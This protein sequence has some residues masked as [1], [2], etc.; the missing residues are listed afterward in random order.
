M[1]LVCQH[2]NVLFWGRYAGKIHSF[3]F[4]SSS[5][6]YLFQHVRRTFRNIL[7]WFWILLLTWNLIYMWSENDSALLTCQPI[8]WSHAHRFTKVRFR[9]SSRVLV[10]NIGLFPTLQKFRSA[11][12]Q[13]ASRSSPRGFI[14]EDPHIMWCAFATVPTIAGIR[15][16]LNYIWKRQKPRGKFVK[17]VF[18]FVFWRS[19]EKFVW[20]P[21][22]FGERLRL[23]PLSLA[24]SIPILGLERVCPRKGWRKFT[25]ISLV[26]SIVVF[27]GKF[28][29]PLFI[30]KCFVF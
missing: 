19:P 9:T 3:N 8:T 21:F 26:Y 29:F 16:F 5:S 11:L 1:N 27:V 7:A 30:T 15:S 28:G 20:K 10:L 14:S 23:C 6:T 13:C 22:F 24:S 18:I 17:T 25:L 12:T 2:I 4:C